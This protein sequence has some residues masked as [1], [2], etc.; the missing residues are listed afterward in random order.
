MKETYHVLSHFK[1]FLMNRTNVYYRFFI[2]GCGGTGGYVAQ[3]IAQMRKMMSPS[4]SIFLIDPD[5][6]EQKN[7]NNQLF[8][9]K[10]IGKSK[11]EVLRNRYTMA[12]GQGISYY[13]AKYIETIE[14]LHQ[15]VY[16]K[17]YITNVDARATVVL[18]V[19][20]GCVDNN[21]TRKLIH[22]YFQKVP[23]LIYIDSGVEGGRVPEG[24]H[25]S[26]IYSWTK[27]EREAYLNS[28]YRGQ[29]VIGVRSQG[30]TILPPVGEVFPNILRDA[31]HEIKPSESCSSLLRSE[32]QRL[33][34]NR[35]AALIIAGYIN[36]LLA[37][38]TI[39]NHYS[40]FNSRE[41][42]ISTAPLPTE[43]DLEIYA[44]LQK[45]NA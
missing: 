42:T 36:E 44:E 21:F 30:K 12:Y 38:N 5:I 16:C 11:A 26:T 4:S 23:N 20:I 32:P 27:E 22:D 25:I 28:G 19:I 34:T 18:N 17:N 10:D 3:H 41:N 1:N 6:V 24:K 35:F 45:T 15:I 39:R 33:I 7:L 9:K 40:T 31:E 8:I 14:E 43:E 29:V 37:N 2:L 13:D